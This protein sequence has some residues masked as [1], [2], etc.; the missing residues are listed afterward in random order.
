M[1]P[2]AVAF[3][4]TWVRVRASTLTLAGLIAT[5]LGG[6]SDD[7]DSSSGRSSTAR[8]TEAKVSG[9][10]DGSVA[11]SPR[12]AAF[13][14]G[15]PG[16]VLYA[17]A[18]PR[19]DRT[20][21][22]LRILGVE[23]GSL[24]DFEGYRLARNVRGQIP[25]YV[26]GR[27]TNRG[28]DALESFGIGNGMELFDRRGRAAGRA[29]TSLATQPEVCRV[30]DPTQPW[31]PGRTFEDCRIFFLRDGVRPGEVRFPRSG[32]YAITAERLTWRP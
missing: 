25:Y 31:R 11:L 27:F 22:E 29:V 18:P 20:K 15:E 16:V 14:F 12:G 21:I 24:K 28:P 32:G 5:A 8:T 19:R 6:C 13:S 9:P 1:T 2:G 17:S 26:R 3:S 4:L 10:V 23:R 7:S 30:N